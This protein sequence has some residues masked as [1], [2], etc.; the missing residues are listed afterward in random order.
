MILLIFVSSFSAFT[1][2]ASAYT[3]IICMEISATMTITVTFFTLT[4]FF[5]QLKSQLTILFHN[6]LIIVVFSSINITI[7]SQPTQIQPSI[8]IALR[9]SQ[10]QLCPHFLH[11]IIFFLL[12]FVEEPIG[13][14][15]LPLPRVFYIPFRSLNLPIRHFIFYCK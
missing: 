5:C 13:I 14:F 12:N 7:C 1:I 15:C 11:L 10:W 4:H 3:I 8:H 9:V 6:F 2:I